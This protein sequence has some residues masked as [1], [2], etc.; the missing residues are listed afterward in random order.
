MAT[1]KNNLAR[2]TVK[3]DPDDECQFIVCDPTGWIVDF[4]D[5]REV[6]DTIA[7]NMTRQRYYRSISLTACDNA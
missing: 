3:V 7:S 5:T 1:F 4:A 6:A 2:Y